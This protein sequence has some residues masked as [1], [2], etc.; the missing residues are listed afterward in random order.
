[1]RRILTSSAGFSLVEMMTVLMVVGVLMAI[2][3]PA[4][5]NH[6]ALQEIRGT[7][8][9]VVQTLRDARDEAL[10]EGVPRY[11]LFDPAVSP[12]TYRVYRYTGGAW[13]TETQAEPFP[14][15]VT[16]ADADVAFPQLSN[17]PVAGATVPDNAAYFDTRGKYPFQAGAPSS[18][19]LTLH[20]GLGKVVVLTLHRSTGQVTGL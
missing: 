2:A 16:F 19:D 8:Q 7:A 14:S 6:I 12:R 11:V 17:T 9:E 5:Q 13:V 3:A 18:Y 4:I 1:M 15:S 20:G 10:N